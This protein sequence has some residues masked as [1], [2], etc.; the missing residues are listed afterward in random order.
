MDYQCKI[1]FRRTGNHA[2]ADALSRLPIKEKE[3]VSTETVIATVETDR[4][5]ATN[6]QADCKQHLQEPSAIPIYF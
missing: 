2:N 1:Q 3:L 6:S 4:R 5:Y